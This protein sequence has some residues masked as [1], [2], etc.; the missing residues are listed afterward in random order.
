MTNLRLAPLALAHAENLGVL[1][2]LSRGKHARAPIARP[3]S[4]PDP[5][6]GAGSHPDVVE[7]VWDQLGKDLPR[8]ARVLVYGS[9]ALVHA[10]GGLVVALALGTQ[11]ALRVPREAWAEAAQAGLAAVHTYRSMG[12][13]LDLAAFGPGWHF[14]IWHAREPVWLGLEYA[15]LG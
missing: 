15:R 10:D 14:G 12:E 8:A 6:Q 2:H 7:R 4:V 3:S 1:A 11:Y 9:P 5:Y 13:R